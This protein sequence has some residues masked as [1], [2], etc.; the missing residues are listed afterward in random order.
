MSETPGGGK[1]TLVLTWAYAMYSGQRRSRGN[2]LDARS[3]IATFVRQTKVLHIVESMQKL[4]RYR[5]IVVITRQS[6]CND[7]LAKRHDMHSGDY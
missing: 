6:E 7:E 3:K 5:T 1:P 2:H 4:L